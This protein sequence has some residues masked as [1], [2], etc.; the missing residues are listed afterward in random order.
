MSDKPSSLGTLLSLS[1]VVTLD[2]LVMGIVFPLMGGLF[3]DP[4]YSIVPDGTS[5]H[6]RDFLYSLAMGIFFLCVI[7]GAPF[8][9]DL[10]DRIGRRKVLLLTVFMAGISC[11]LSAMAIS[12]KFVTLLVLARAAAG[13]M[14]GN[15]PLAMAAM[16]DISTPYTKARNISLITM[17]SAVGFAVGPLIGGVF[18]DATLFKFSNYS[19]PFLIAAALAFLNAAGLMFTF[20]ETFVPPTEVKKLDWKK[21]IYLLIEGFRHQTLKRWIWISFLEQLGWGIFFQSTSLV[22]IQFHH[23]TTGRVGFFMFYLSILFII[24]LSLIVPYSVKKYKLTD[25]INA[26][27]ILLSVS[28]LLN[29]IFIKSTLAF[30]IILIPFVIGQAILFTT[31]TTGMSNAV[32]KNA[33]GWVMGIAAAVGSFAWGIASFVSGGIIALSLYLPFI[34]ALILFLAALALNRGNQA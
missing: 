29:I 11:L 20:K 30:W 9:G 6:M 4:R 1:L 3:L 31:I 8:L 32:D 13:L 12:L 7:V 33:Q 18:S 34:T 17:A 16:I 2:A 14:S 27:L 26:S 28:M 23:Y 19:T 25:L 21:G 10:S 15:Q 24:S 22:L 5:M